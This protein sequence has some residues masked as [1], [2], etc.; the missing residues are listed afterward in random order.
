MM[1]NRLQKQPPAPD[2]DID[3]EGQPFILYWVYEFWMPQEKKQKLA[4]T[5]AKYG[6]DPEEYL[7]YGIKC[8]L[9]NEEIARALY[10]A[11]KADPE[12]EE[13]IKLLCHYPVHDN[14]TED[15]AREHAVIFYREHE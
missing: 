15:E 10:E 13:D 8:I 6:M 14:E 7:D 3:P 9:A 5:A 4:E 1:E 2:T 11:W 12:A